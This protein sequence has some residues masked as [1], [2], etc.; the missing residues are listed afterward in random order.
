MANLCKTLHTDFYPNWSTFAEVK[1]VLV[2][3]Y[4]PRFSYCQLVISVVEYL[5]VLSAVFLGLTLY[6]VVRTDGL[7]P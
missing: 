4:A 3:F 2:C 7:L 1:S 5:P 6:D